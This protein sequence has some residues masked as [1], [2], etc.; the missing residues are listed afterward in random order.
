MDKDDKIYRY[1]FIWLLLTNNFVIKKRT[2]LKIQ[3]HYFILDVL[4]HLN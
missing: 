2:S 3:L 1:L 4:K